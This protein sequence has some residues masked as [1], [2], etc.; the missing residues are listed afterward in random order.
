MMPNMWASYKIWLNELYQQFPLYKT[1]KIR[2]GF[3]YGS[4][5]RTI[6]RLHEYHSKD[7]KTNENMV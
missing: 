2:I 3:S 7:W 6:A 4:Y 1:L 5:A